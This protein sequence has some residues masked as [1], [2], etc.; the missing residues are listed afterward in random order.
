[1]SFSSSYAQVTLKGIY[2]L[3]RLAKAYGELPGVKFADLDLRVA[4]G[5][6]ICV[7]REDAAWHYVYD[8]A[9]GD[10]C[11]A[12]CTAHELRHFTVTSSGTVT[13]LGAL[14]DAERAIYRTPEA[15]R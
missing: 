2:N 11:I 3:E 1:V 15:C 8:I 14:S 4:S 5:S 6:T 12:G 13:A 7:V 9:G 10:D